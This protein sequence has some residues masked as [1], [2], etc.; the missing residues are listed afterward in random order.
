M[1]ISA[2]RAY[3]LGFLV[4]ELLAVN[5]SADAHARPVRAQIDVYGD[6]TTFGQSRPSPQ[7]PLTRVARPAP[8]VLQSELARSARAE[9][10]VSN[11]GVPAMRATDL[12]A[13]TDGVHPPWAQMAPTSKAHV[14]VFNYA[15]NDA[16]RDTLTDYRLHLEGLVAVARAN[17]MIPVLEEPNPVCNQLGPRLD[18]FVDTLRAVAAEQKVPLIA[19][20]DAIKTIPNWQAM[21]PDCIHPNQS[22]Y[23]IKGRQMAKTLTPIIN[24]LPHDGH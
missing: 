23:E 18:R 7:C 5:Y 13:G 12:L 14:V 15:I 20:Y 8:T 11:Q 21:V 3:L 19:H 17:G 2:A 24:N 22:L 9:V 4:F 10:V 6:S 1:M 16:W